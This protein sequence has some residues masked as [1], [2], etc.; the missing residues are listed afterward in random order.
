[1]I[2]P[3]FTKDVG[4][5]DGRIH[6]IGKAEIHYPAERRHH[7]RSRNRGH[8]GRGHPDG[9]FDSHIHLF[10]CANGRPPF[11]RHVFW[12][13]YGPAHGTLATTC[14]LGPW[15]I[16]RMLQS[17]DGIPMNLGLS[18]KGNASQPAAWSLVMRCFSAKAA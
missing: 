18:G 4:L 15:H 9:G 13:W 12:R 11:W 16:G 7:R 2:I 10:A 8:C 5:K 17:F 6:K 3:E 1:L 14:T